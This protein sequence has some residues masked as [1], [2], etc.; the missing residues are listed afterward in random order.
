MDS[1]KD[2][3]YDLIERDDIDSWGI[4]LTKGKYTGVEYSYGKVSIKELPED[5]GSGDALLTFDYIVHEFP[6]SFSKD[7]IENAEDFHQNIGDV[8]RNIIIEIAEETVNG[9]EPRN[10]NTSE[11]TDERAVRASGYSVSE[12]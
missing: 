5:D 6:E 11:S 1:N 10:D 3:T 2:K 12:S 7:E 4:R 8:L 9:S